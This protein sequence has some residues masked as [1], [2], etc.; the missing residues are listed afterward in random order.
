MSGEVEEDVDLGRAST[1]ELLGS[2][3][4]L[5]M[6]DD[7]AEGHARRDPTPPCPPGRPGSAI[8]PGEGFLIGDP[9]TFGERIAD[10][11]NGGL[12]LVAFARRTGAG[13]EAITVGAKG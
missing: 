1:P 6:V 9:E 2:R 3:P 13:P 7:G 10:G 4:D 8:K 11:E 5:A 12:A